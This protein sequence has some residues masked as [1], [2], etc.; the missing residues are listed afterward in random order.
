MKKLLV[1]AI[2]AAIGYGA[3]KYMEQV[4]Q[5]AAAKHDAVNPGEKALK[6]MDAETK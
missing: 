6:Q 1:I 5:K 4:Q 3:Y 2:I